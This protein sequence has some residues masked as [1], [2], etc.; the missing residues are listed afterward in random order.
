MAVLPSVKLPP[1]WSDNRRDSTQDLDPIYILLYLCESAYKYLTQLGTL[2]T[3]DAN[4]TEK[5]SAFTAE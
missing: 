3:P 1:I 2:L 5:N 4:W